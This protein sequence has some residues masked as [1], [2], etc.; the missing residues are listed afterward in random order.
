[1]RSTVVAPSSLLLDAVLVRRAREHEASG[2]QTITI[3]AVAA[4]LAGGFMSPID[5]DALAFAVGS[6]L[7]DAGNV[8]LGDL[9]SLRDLPGVRRTLVSTLQRAWAAGFDLA[10]NAARHPRIAT[11]AHIEEAVLELVPANQLRPFDLVSHALA[12][13]ALA[14]KV[15]GRVDFRGFADLPRCWHPLVVALAKV[16]PVSWD[17]G[18]MPEPEWLGGSGITVLHAAP[19]SPV[20]R[21]ASCASARHEVVEAMRWARSLLATGS[22]R[23]QEIAL[24]ATSTDFYDD[25]I[26]TAAEEANLPVHFA[27]GRNAL[28]TSAGQVAAALADVLLRGL[29][30]ERV[31][32]LA[33]RAASPGTPL[34][35]LPERWWTKLPTDAPLANADR[36]RLAL[37][38]ADKAD[39]ARVLLP[40]IKVLARGPEA[41]AEAGELLLRGLPREL[42][43]RAMANAPG[44]ALELELSRLRPQDALDPAA[45]IAWMPADTLASCPRPFV[46]LLGLNAQTWPRSSADDSL[47]P[48]HVLGDFALA[49]TTTEADRRSYEA[50]LMSTAC[51]VVQSFSRRE[52]TG[53]K[54]GVSP[55]VDSR[56]AVELSRSRIPEHAMSEP[57]RMLARPD[58]FAANDAAR[59][60]DACWRAWR[61]PTIGPHD[62]LVPAG[63]PALLR[64]LARTQSASSLE[65]LIRNPI[66]FMWRYALG[67]DAPDLDEDPVELDPRQFGTLVHEILHRAVVDIETSNI[68]LGQANGDEIGACV[69]RAVALTGM[70]WEVE[71]PIPP[72]LLWTLTLRR[73][74]ILV[75]NALLHPFQSMDGQK[76]FSEVP[77][78]GDGQPQPSRRLPWDAMMPVHIPDVGLRIGGR[79]DRLDI[80]GNG[81]TARVVD[82][83]TGRQHGDYVLRGGRELQR[84]LYAFA[85]RALLTDV[86]HIEAALLYPSHGL[87]GP[88]GNAYTPL[89]APTKTLEQLSQTLALA[90]QNMRNGLAI[91]GVAAG[92]RY[93]DTRSHKD[94]RKGEEDRLSFALP[95]VPGTMLEPKKLAAQQLLGAM[96]QFWEAP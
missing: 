80:S 42:W 94:N 34:A 12:R 79:I 71:R 9:V 62:G 6:V 7:K 20:T 91:P 60:A 10:A 15:L 69:E 30:Q 86:A 88:S 92:A 61:D 31:R 50:I 38:G 48:Q 23:P 32:R 95:V 24:A 51:E 4:R 65:L 73:A 11:L 8:N 57:D 63:H 72:G 19:L 56:T 1:M 35:A 89:G 87:E 36:W 21:L 76:S 58:E 70:A 18:P 67:L 75:L 96:P 53:R 17:A 14:P 77:F 44:G 47:L 28:H 66:G 59:Q 84:C 40:V 27:H 85:V 68:G 83:K 3:A 81:S 37:V 22:A 2:L 90:C 39:V 93:A 13:V 49:E 78:G 26:M 16:V 55:L 33:A 41:A 25:H 45:S 82:Y 5:P 46:W 43:R 74:E 64:S 29:S 52:V 54:L